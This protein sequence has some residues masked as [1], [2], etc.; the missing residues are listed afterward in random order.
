M[1]LDTHGGRRKNAGRKHTKARKSEPHRRR[2]AITSAERA[3]VVIRVERVGG[4][5]RRSRCDRA[6]SPC[7]AGTRSTTFLNNWRT[8]Q[9]QHG[10]G[11]DHWI[12]DGFSSASRFAGW[13]AEPVWRMPERNEPLAVSAPATWLVRAGWATATAISMNATPAQRPG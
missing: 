11:R 5:L 9:E 12:L 4:G 2:A 13:R 6:I 10:R 8:H 1:V 7:S 3:R